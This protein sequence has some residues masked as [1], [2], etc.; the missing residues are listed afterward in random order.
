VRVGF[1]TNGE[2]LWLGEMTLYNLAGR[3]SRGGSDPDHPAALAWD[4]RKAHFLRNPPQ[5]GWRAGYAQ[6]L[7]R[8]LDRQA[9]EGAG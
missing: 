5:T 7:R 9:A 8:E 2:V 6:A 1:L 3:F 4:L